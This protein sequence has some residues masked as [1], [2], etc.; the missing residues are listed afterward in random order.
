[1]ILSVRNLEFFR[2][3]DLILDRVSFD[4][5]EGSI[6]GLT[7]P[8]GGGKTTL[9]EILLGFRKATAGEIQWSRRCLSA[10]VPQQTLP[11]KVLPLTVKEFVKMGTWGPHQKEAGAA[12]SFEEALEALH[13]RSFSQKMISDLSG[14]EWKRAALARCLVQAADVYFLDEPFNH[15]DLQMENQIGHLLQ[16]ISRE[17]KKTF[18]I[19]SHDWH[20]MD[21][22]FERLLLLN[23]R[24]IAEGSVREVS[25][26]SMNW[27]DPKH[28]EWMH[29]A[30]E[31]TKS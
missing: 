28:H 12:L 16:N 3:R 5:E 7:G 22:F 10:Y 21:H 23:K 15:L 31:E 2:Q 4:L 29:T 26:I 1:M 8:N 17:K 18:F 20:A 25:D 13:L 9:F 11:R 27:R 14:G 19:I 24:L 30:S 6:V